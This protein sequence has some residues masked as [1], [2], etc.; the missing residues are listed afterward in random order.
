MNDNRTE[1]L[2]SA[3]KIS[4]TGLAAQRRKLNAITENLANIHT[5]KTAEGGPYKRKIVRFRE[6]INRVRS[7]S[8]IGKNRLQMNTPRIGHFDNEAS[9][10]KWQF[11]GVKAEQM[12][13]ESPPILIYDPSHPDA[14]EFGN[15]RMPNIN[16]VTEMVNMITAQR[17]YEANVTAIKVTKSMVTKALEM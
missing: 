8:G 1:G 3:L 6:I 4:A 7:S 9:L 11:S 13:D 14:D 15:V 12:R 2:F 10:K 16:I 17:A 5:T